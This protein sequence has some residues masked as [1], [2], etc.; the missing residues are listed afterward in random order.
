MKRFLALLLAFCM[1]VPSVAFAAP[2]EVSTASVSDSTYNVYIEGFAETKSVSIILRNDD[3][4]K[5]AYVGEVTPDSQ[6]NG[7]YAT[8]FKVNGDID[9]YKIY[10]R[11]VETGE[12]IGNSIATAVAKDE[13]YTASLDV[14]VGA[15]N[16]TYFEQ[17][18][19]VN[20][21]VDVKNKYGDNETMKVLIAAYGDENTLLDVASTTVTALFADLEATKNASTKFAVPAGAKK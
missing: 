15:E 14:S 19:A 18:D 7:K 20:V 10:V 4:T 12:D 13:L 8:K 9:D 2:E 16:R 17:D 6:K 21:S 3:G 1:L 5:I 11:D